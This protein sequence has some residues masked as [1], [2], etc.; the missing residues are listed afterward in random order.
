MGICDDPKHR[1]KLMVICRFFLF[2]YAEYA[3][4]VGNMYIFYKML[5]FRFER[6]VIAN[7]LFAAVSDFN[8]GVLV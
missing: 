3:I 2:E 1:E 7:G 6:V 4:N 5:F 8:Y